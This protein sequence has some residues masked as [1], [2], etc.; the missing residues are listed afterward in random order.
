MTAGIDETTRTE[1]DDLVTTVWATTLGIEI[2]PCAGD[3]AAQSP[4]PWI[5]A[6]VHITDAWRGVVVLHATERLGVIVAR[7]LFA[8]EA[9][10]ADDIQDAMGE[11]ANIT[12]GNI[13]GLLPGGE[14]RL[15]LPSVVCGRDYH[16]HVP[17][18]ELL[19]RADFVAAGEP[20]VVTLLRAPAPA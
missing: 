14:L 2:E 16:V 18:S 20:F 1:I 6:Q 13:K 10:T 12:G 7:R 11:L 4:G 17:G 15:S 19:Q 3:V 8:A 5:E 9:V